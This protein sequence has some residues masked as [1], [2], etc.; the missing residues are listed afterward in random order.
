[1]ISAYQPTQMGGIWRIL[2][3]HAGHLSIAIDIEGERS[4]YS[5]YATSREKVC[6]RPFGALRRPGV[7]I[8]LYSSVRP[9]GISSILAAVDK[10]GPALYIIEPNGFYVGGC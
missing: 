5:P 9:F 4:S 8:A 7:Y 3:E 6:V 10:D 2:V 1:M